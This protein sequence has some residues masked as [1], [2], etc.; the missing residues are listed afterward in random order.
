MSSSIPTVEQYMTPGRMS[1]IDTQSI[2]EAADFLLSKRLTGCAVTNS[3]GKLVGFVSE[4][5]LLG[6]LSNRAYYDTEAAVVS[7]VMHSEPL[8]VA[9][10]LDIFDLAVQMCQPKPKVYPVVNPVT[11]ELLGEINRSQILRALLENH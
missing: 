3:S 7:E 11:Q 6:K 8:T 4:Q 10:D 9:P 5:D 1:I 2:T